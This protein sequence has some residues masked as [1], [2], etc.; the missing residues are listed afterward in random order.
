MIAGYVRQVPRVLEGPLVEKGT[1]NGV[2]DRLNDKS[3]L[4]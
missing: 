1:L 2:R 4:K 3:K